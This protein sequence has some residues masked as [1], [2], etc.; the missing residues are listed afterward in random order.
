MKRFI[1]AFFTAVLLLCLTVPAPAAWWGGVTRP[2]LEKD[3]AGFGAD[4]VRNTTRQVETV[5]DLQ[6]LPIPNHAKAVYLQSRGGGVF[7]WS[8]A[9][10]S[11]DVAADPLKGITVAPVSDATGSGGAWRRVYSGGIKPE[12]FVA[13]GDGVA[14]D[15]AAIQAA[16]DIGGLVVGDVDKL[17]K[18]TS[19]T[20]KKDGTSLKNLRLTS[21]VEGAG[22]TITTPSVTITSQPLV[23]AV[24][25]Y[26]YVLSVTDASV[27]SNYAYIES[28]SGQ[29][30]IVEIDSID[31]STNK[32]TLKNKV[33]MSFSASDIVS[34]ISLIKDLAI[35][36]C[37]IT[38]TG[39]QSDGATNNFKSVAVD[40]VGVVGAKIVNVKI[41][42]AKDGGAR[43]MYSLNSEVIGGKIENA[44]AE[45]AAGA[46]YTNAY[47]VLLSKS[48]Y[49]RAINNSTKNNGLAGII[50]W[51]SSFSEIVNNVIWGS[52]NPSVVGNQIGI[53]VSNAYANVIDGNTVTNTDDF[54]IGLFGDCKKCTVSNNKIVASRY[55]GIKLE[56][57]AANFAPSKTIIS[58]NSISNSGGGIVVATGI[59]YATHPA[60]TCDY[61]T[62]SGNIITDLMAYDV[63]NPVTRYGITVAGDTDSAAPAR[64]IGA[65]I[66]GNIVVSS[67]VESASVGIVLRN[68]ESFIVRGNYVKVSSS[69]LRLTT[70]ASGA[71]KN[72]WHGIIISNIL[73]GVPDFDDT[74]TLRGKS[75]FAANS[76]LT[77]TGTLYPGIKTLGGDAA[78][79][80]VTLEDAASTINTFG[81]Y[82]GKT[83]YNVTTGKT[84]TATGDTPTAVWNLADGTVAHTPI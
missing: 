14:D 73:N 9:D 27:F 36:D 35:V 47:G 24:N 50:S 60:A 13:V 44:G 49:C 26:D 37:S 55:A 19:I 76:L 17:Y 39:T 48:T 41:P 61:I 70:D 84:V 2:Q 3:G 8:S 68:V 29:S 25:A 82:K 58:N 52:P 78:A 34:P 77:G 83:V 11:A 10:H 64:L 31:I 23:A 53:N 79:T 45:H 32:L 43:L 72:N 59:F 81:K 54:G 12:W 1:S 21:A 33:G 18:I 7:V 67:S 22:A 46:A 74:G 51:N 30:V 4:M 65:T 5:A 71:P 75:Y 69:A 66:T 63:G 38:E 57:S 56:D 28:V 16:L 6:A 62:I 40:L 20:I 80:T 42:R 15:T